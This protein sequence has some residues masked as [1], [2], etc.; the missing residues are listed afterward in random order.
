M[1]IFFR[2]IQGLILGPIEGLTAVIMVQAFPPR[3]RGMAIGL[4][5]IGWSVGQIVSFTVGGYCLEQLIF[6]GL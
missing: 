2:T 4:R 3:Q 6:K 5:S 1:L